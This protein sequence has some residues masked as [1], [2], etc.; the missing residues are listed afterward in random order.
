MRFFKR[1]V[2]KFE[3]EMAAA[4]IAQSG[5]TEMAREIIRESLPDDYHDQPS[6]HKQEMMQFSINPAEGK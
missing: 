2:R 1:V 5:E 3:D 4:A 6:Q